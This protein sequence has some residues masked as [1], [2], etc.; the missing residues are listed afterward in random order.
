MWWWHLPPLEV[1]EH[2]VHHVRS[3]FVTKLRKVFFGECEDAGLSRKIKSNYCRMT[4]LAVRDCLPDRRHRIGN[5]FQGVPLTRSA[6]QDRASDSTYQGYSSGPK[7]PWQPSEAQACR[8]SIG[9]GWI[10]CLSDRKILAQSES[11]KRGRQS[12]RG[13]PWRWICSKAC[14]GPPG[15]WGTWRCPGTSKHRGVKLPPR[16]HLSDANRARFEANDHHLPRHL[17]SRNLQTSTTE[18]NTQCAL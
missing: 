9:P 12:P 16:N 4:N 7:R 17:L 2:W 5:R 3:P 10:L 13:L 1:W 14:A 6:A 11:S 8:A 18:W 15:P